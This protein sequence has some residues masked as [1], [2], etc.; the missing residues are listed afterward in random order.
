MKKDKTS[1]KSNFIVRY[2]KPP[3][4]LEVITCDTFIGDKLPSGLKNLEVIACDTFIGTKMFSYADLRLWQNRI[5]K[6]N[7]AKLKRLEMLI[8][9]GGNKTLFF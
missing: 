6:D 2:Q 8:S 9:L 3:K 7:N 4:N 1:A 5:I